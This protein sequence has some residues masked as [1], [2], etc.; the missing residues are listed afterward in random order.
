MNEAKV[1]GAYRGLILGYLRS[2]ARSYHNLV[3]VK[4]LEGVRGDDIVGCKV[5]L[6]DVHGNRYVGRVV[7][8]H[9][10]KR[11]VVKVRFK[12]NIPGQAV[13]AMVAILCGRGSS[14]V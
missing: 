1:E 6:T 11:E 12:P 13:N 8:V 5:L 7:G 3:L 4:V 2:R 9:G 14:S 10:S